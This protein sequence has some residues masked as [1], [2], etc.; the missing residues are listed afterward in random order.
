MP[1]TEGRAWSPV[2]RRRED[3]HEDDGERDADEVDRT[4]RPV[5]SRVPQELSVVVVLTHPPSDPYIREEA[6]DRRLYLD[7]G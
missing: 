3:R 7:F 1:A 4:P 6:V 5:L 2:Q